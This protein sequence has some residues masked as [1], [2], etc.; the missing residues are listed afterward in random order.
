MDGSHTTRLNL[1]NDE[2]AKEDGRWFE[3]TTPPRLPR[4]TLTR[5]A[6]NSLFDRLSGYPVVTLSAPAGF[7]KSVSLLMW[8]D[9]RE[10]NYS[11]FAPTESYVELAFLQRWFEQADQPILVIDDAHWLSPACWHFIDK[12]VPLLSHQRLFILSRS[13]VP[14]NLSAMKAEG[15]VAS[16]GIQALQFHEAE[17]KALC[18]LRQLE[19]EVCQLMPESIVAWP[20]AVQLW[21]SAALRFGLEVV[22]QPQWRFDLQVFLEQEWLA[23]LSDA[24]KEVLVFLAISP[25]SKAELFK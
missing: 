7:S 18:H 8:L 10:L 3:L 14:L 9:A 2:M 1:T 23:N 13:P 16:V 21:L 5:E 4:Y 12:R 25:A 15:L 6:V 22:Q 19:P 11:W 17:S 24:Q 20:A